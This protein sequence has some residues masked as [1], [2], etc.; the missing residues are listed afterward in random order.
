ME[1]KRRNDL[2]EQEK[3][4]EEELKKLL[5]PETFKA[6]ALKWEEHENKKSKM[7]NEFTTC[8]SKRT[9]PLP[10][11]KISYIIN[12]QKVPTI[13]ITRD[14]DPLNLTVYLNF[15]L[16]M[17]GFNEWMEVHALASKKTGKSYDA[18]LQNKKRKRSE[19]IKEVFLTEDVRVEGMHRNLIPPPGIRPIQ[20]LVIS[21]PESGIFFMNGN[22]VIG[23]Q[24]ESEFHLTPTIKLIRLQR[25]IKV[26]SQIAKEISA[27]CKASANDEDQLIAK[28]QLVIKGLVDGKALVSN[29][30]IYYL[31][32]Y[33]SAEMD[34]NVCSRRKPLKVLKGES[35]VVNTL[36]D[37]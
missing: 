37:P 16:R 15:K 30:E 21:E 28:H 26:D 29:L 32:T 27:G 13:R 36:D 7:L 18:L 5:N 24:R 9:N 8:I 17:L 10:I 14:N 2:K 4:S 12:S 19:V 6:Q 11:T 23:F 20:G 34:M 1:I 31:K 22:T 33:S 25:Q 3:K 35:G